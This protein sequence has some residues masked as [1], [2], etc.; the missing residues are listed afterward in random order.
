MGERTRTCMIVMIGP[1]MACC[2]TEHSL[3]TL[4]YADRVK[5]FCV[6]ESV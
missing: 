6:G 2:E 5:G 3:N 1:C 4:H